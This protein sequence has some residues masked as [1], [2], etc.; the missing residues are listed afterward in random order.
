MVVTTNGEEPQ[1]DT[2]GPGWTS[3][4]L[5][6]LVVVV[7][8]VG[9]LVLF[10]TIGE[11]NVPFVAVPPSN[12]V[13]SPVASSSSSSTPPPEAA[14][15]PLGAVE[16][17]RLVGG[18][19]FERA[20]SGPDLRRGGGDVVGPETL[21]DGVVFGWGHQWDEGPVWWES[22]ASNPVW[23]DRQPRWIELDLGE[24]TW[25]LSVT[26]Q[27]DS[28]DEYLLSHLDLETGMWM[29]LWC[30]FPAGDGE[31]RIRRHVLP[32]PVRAQFL[33]F[34]AISGDG[35]YSVAEISIE[36]RELER[37]WGRWDEDA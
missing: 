10:G 11:Q 30:L 16:A 24:P 18:P 35:M 34:E 15:E 13:T 23:G 36:S 19:F 1:P 6:V 14:A 29:P 32:Q 21:M 12:T 20:T 9:G 17:V 3:G 8:A 5:P 31:M 37:V 27:A 28:N 4:F 22:G 7:L 2:G 33:R 26:I 25:I